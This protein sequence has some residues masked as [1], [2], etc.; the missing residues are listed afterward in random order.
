[1]KIT[2]SVS[3][4]SAVLPQKSATRAFFSAAPVPRSEVKKSV[5]AM[6]SAMSAAARG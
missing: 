1:M 4:Q 5:R 6:Y 2:S 3:L